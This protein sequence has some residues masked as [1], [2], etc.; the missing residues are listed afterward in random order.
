MQLQLPTII[1]SSTSYTYIVFPSFSISHSPNH[2]SYSPGWHS[3]INC[4]Y[5]SPSPVLFFFSLGELRLKKV[6]KKSME[7]IVMLETEET[8]LQMWKLIP[9]EFSCIAYGHIVQ[10]RNIWNLNWVSWLSFN[11]FQL[12]DQLML[13]SHYLFKEKSIYYFYRSGLVTRLRMKSTDYFMLKQSK[14]ILPISPHTIAIRNTLFQHFSVH[15]Y[16]D[17]NV[18]TGTKKIY[19]VCV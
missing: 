8:T 18:N 13:I 15:L 2:H 14:I 11:A 4:L 17:R 1:T 7:V 10:Q 9:V 3:Q 19:G 5:K 12:G 16:A 6:L